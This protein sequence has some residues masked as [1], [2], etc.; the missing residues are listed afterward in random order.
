MQREG[1]RGRKWGD[2]LNFDVCIN[3]SRVVIKE[4]VPAVAKMLDR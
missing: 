1:F 3:T 2:K 4:I